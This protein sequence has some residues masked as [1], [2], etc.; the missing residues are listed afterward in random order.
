MEK[1]SVAVGA[2]PNRGGRRRRARPRGYML[3]SADGASGVRAYSRGINP[4]T[5]IEGGSPS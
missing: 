4:P 1:E 2:Y 3:R 5:M